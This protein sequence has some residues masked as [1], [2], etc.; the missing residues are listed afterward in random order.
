MTGIA[1]LLYGWHKYTDVWGQQKRVNPG[2]AHNPAKNL[3]RHAKDLARFPNLDL[4]VI[5]VLADVVLENANPLDP[6]STIT[7]A[8]YDFYTT[9]DQALTDVPSMTVSSTIS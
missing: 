3:I 7:T 6:T 2:W 8:L 5:D 4:V 1:N 9:I